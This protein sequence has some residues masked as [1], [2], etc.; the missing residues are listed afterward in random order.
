MF[1][2]CDPERR[3]FIF[4]DKKVSDISNKNQESKVSDQRVL[5]LS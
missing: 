3:V 2:K 1:R 5:I 4:N